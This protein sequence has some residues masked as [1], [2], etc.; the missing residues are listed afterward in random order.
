MGRFGWD[1]DRK[2]VATCRAA[3]TRPA[4]P[5]DLEAPDIVRISNPAAHRNYLTDVFGKADS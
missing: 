3:S 4:V 1:R 5:F 2:G